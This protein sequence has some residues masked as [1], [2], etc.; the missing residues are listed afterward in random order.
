[1]GNKL[2]DIFK[3]EEPVLKGEFSFANAEAYNRFFEAWKKVQ[4]EGG[5]ARVG[6][7]VTIKTY[8]KNGDGSEEEYVL[9]EGEVQD[10]VIYEQEEPLLVEA[11]I[12]QE[13]KQIDCRRTMLNSG[14]IIKA[15]VQSVIDFKI[16]FDVDKHTLNLSVTPRLEYAKNTEDVIE[17]YKIADAIF[18]KFLQIDEDSP[19]L[20]DEQK[21]QHQ[22]EME[23]I[24][25]LL[26]RIR[27]ETRIF[28]VVLLIEREL[29]LKFDIAQFAKEPEYLQD[30]EE[31]Y[32]ALIKQLP[33]R[34]NAKITSSDTQ[35][36]NIAHVEKD[37]EIGDPI[38]ITFGSEIIYNICGTEIKLFTANIISNAVVKKILPQ[39]NEQTKIIYG[40]DDV[41]PMFISYRVYMTEAEAKKEAHSMIERKE[42]YI[43]AKAIYE[44]IAE[45]GLN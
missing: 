33:I 23:Q 41:C 42:E 10:L 28:E 14:M 44:Y 38:N 26:D 36:I 20:S 8:M 13:K 22:K 37:L 12:D 4:N 29:N 25:P 27:Q 9:H 7:G 6:N 45:N 39:E 18:R 43:E 5:S 21:K 11:T 32:F 34:L 2:R 16:H 15:P 30:A 31:L 17:S 3:N 24:A 35:G 19:K 40:D 1:M